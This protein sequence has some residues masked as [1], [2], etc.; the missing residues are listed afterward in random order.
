MIE[1]SCPGPVDVGD[2][3][4]T[5]AVPSCRER[6]TRMIPGERKNSPST[7]VEVLEPKTLLHRREPSLMHMALTGNLDEILN[8]C[9]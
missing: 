2:I 3:R 1:C 4:F 7:S 5:Q 8:N 6:E 9:F